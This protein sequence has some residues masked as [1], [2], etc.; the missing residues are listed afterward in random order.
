MGSIMGACRPNHCSDNVCRYDAESMEY[1]GECPK[2]EYPSL[3]LP[4]HATVELLGKKLPSI[5]QNLVVVDNNGCLTDA[6]ELANE[7][8]GNGAFAFVTQAKSK[9]T[10]AVCAVK[11]IC[12]AQCNFHQVK[13]EIAVMKALDH[14]HVVKLHETFQ[15]REYVYIVL[16]FCAGGDLLERLSKEGHFTE[17]QA[18]HAMQQLFHA[19]HYMHDALYCHRDIKPKNCMLHSTSPLEEATLKLIDF[20]LTCKI[21]KQKMMTRRVGSPWYVSP[22]VLDGCYDKSCDLWSCGIV[23]YELLC[24]CPPFNAEKEIDLFIIIKEGKVIFKDAVWCNVSDNATSLILGLL[25]VD[26]AK[27]ASASTAVN[28]PWVRIPIVL[29]V[30]SKNSSM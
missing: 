3:G 20:G 1:V 12:K 28:H 16:E 8:S 14:P 29:R 30:G 4:S 5:P 13:N 25:S 23:M 9:A 17:V 6:Y 24:G 10:G 11:S 18:A 27:R 22:Q 26:P 21:E 19:V 7:K 15:D 2:G